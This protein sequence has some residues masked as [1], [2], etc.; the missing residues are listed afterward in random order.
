MKLD[1]PGHTRV[2]VRGVVR[3][4]GSPRYHVTGNCRPKTEILCYCG[5]CCW[6]VDEIF[7]TDTRGNNE[8]KKK[9]NP[10][11]IFKPTGGQENA[12]V[13]LDGR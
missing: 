10:N 3:A 9:W 1:K 13:V 8:D 5:R 6:G 4:E 7:S 11:T 12:E 2:E